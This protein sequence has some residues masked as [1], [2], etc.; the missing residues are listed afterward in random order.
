M[1]E[2]SPDE[3]GNGEVLAGAV[4]G[5]AVGSHCCKRVRSV[6]GLS[7]Q[8]DRNWEPQK[9]HMRQIKPIRPIAGTWR[10]RKLA[11]DFDCMHIV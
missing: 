11:D 7:L 8:L 5:H 9:L 3:L 4:L 6:R 1:G 10:L 2:V